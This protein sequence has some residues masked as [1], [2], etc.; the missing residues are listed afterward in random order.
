MKPDCEVGP[1][2]YEIRSRSESPTYKFAIEKKDKERRNSV[3]GP[4]TY[5]LE[6]PSK[7]LSSA[8]SINKGER[9]KNTTKDVPGPGS[10]DPNYPQSKAG[11]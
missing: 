10:Y 4:G 6:T 5:N 7:Q 3:P 2:A 1:G 8:Y 11:F 9:F